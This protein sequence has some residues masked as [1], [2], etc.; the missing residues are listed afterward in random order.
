MR[1]LRV[2]EDCGCEC[3]EASDGECGCEESEE[4]CEPGGDC[5]CADFG[6]S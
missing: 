3:C 6:C 5:P 4:I 2:N 1:P